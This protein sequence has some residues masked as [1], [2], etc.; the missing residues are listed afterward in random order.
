[1][2]HRRMLTPLPLEIFPLRLEEVGSVPGAPLLM[3]AEDP[4]Q[5]AALPADLYQ[6]ALV[7]ARDDEGIVLFVVDD[8]I[9]VEPVGLVE[10]RRLDGTLRIDDLPEVPVVDYFAG[11]PVYFDHRIVERILRRAEGEKVPVRQLA[12]VVVETTGYLPAA[13]G[14]S[15]EHVD[16]HDRLTALYH[17]LTVV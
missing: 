5:L 7:S 13:A 14:R 3:V 16:L 17:H 10:I 11:R 2:E 9:Q 6:G 8:R 4:D 12:G 15:S 1:M